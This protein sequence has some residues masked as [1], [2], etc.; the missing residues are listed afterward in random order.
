MCAHTQPCLTLCNPWTVAHQAPLSMGSS[1]QE[2]WCGLPGHPLGD[3]PERGIESASPGLWA[4]FVFT[5]EPLGSGRA[6]KG[7]ARGK[8]EKATLMSEAHWR[9]T[10]PAAD[11]GAN[12]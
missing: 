12:T 8:P 6:V 4:A 2:Y 9:D 10:E 1:Q 5:A 7:S 3:L 11:R